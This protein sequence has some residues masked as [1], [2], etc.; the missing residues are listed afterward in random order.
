LA[1][2]LARVLKT[3]KPKERGVSNV[4]VYQRWSQEVLI[5]R[6]PCSKGGVDLEPLA[7]EK[8]DSIRSGVDC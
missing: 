7:D 3:L 6:M 2:Q 8:F 5:L 4:S 1:S